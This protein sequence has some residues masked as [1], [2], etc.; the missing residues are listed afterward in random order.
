M[1]IVSPL[2]RGPDNNIHGFVMEGECHRLGLATAHT[3]TETSDTLNDMPGV[4]VLGKVR[5]GESSLQ[6]LYRKAEKNTR[7]CYLTYITKQRRR[8][9]CYTQ[10]DFA[11][12]Q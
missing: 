11:A 12:H 10:V 5:T 1:L 7:C 2:G 6:G 4:H 3:Q 8:V 9:S